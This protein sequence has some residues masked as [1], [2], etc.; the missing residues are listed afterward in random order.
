M[1]KSRESQPQHYQQFRLDNS[2]LQWGCLTQCR[3]FSSFPGLYPLDAN[4][5][6]NDK[7]LQT[8]PNNAGIIPAVTLE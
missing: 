2:A 7:C 8:L 1:L 5:I 4:R 3:I 6:D